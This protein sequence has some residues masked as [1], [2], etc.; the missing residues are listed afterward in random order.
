DDQFAP[1]TPKIIAAIKKISS[2][3]IRF[4]LNTHWHFDHT[5][6]NTNI[7]KLGTV[8]VA[9]ENVR[10]LMSKNQFLKAFNAKIPAAPKVALPVITFTTSTTFHLNDETISIR[11]VPPAHTNG[12][13]F[14][15]FKNANVI[16]A[17]DTF[18]NGFYPFIDTQYGG[19]IDGMINAA[20]IILGLADAG[21][22]II[23]GHG[24]LSDKAGLA[25]F[26]A[27]LIEARD[28]IKMSMQGGKTADQVAAADPLKA[29]N[30]K[31][32]NGFLKPDRFV[33]IVY[34][35]MKR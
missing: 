23:P 26:R 12:D 20:G 15:H 34:G 19:S 13:S 1:L 35:G 28:S 4:L 30:P 21:T 33:K 29:L 31:W 25:A 17:G 32:G 3:P 14:V 27:M 11:Y 5:G 18:F 6:G 22:K 10:K 8:I 2:Q 7:G 24:P 16:H 9:H